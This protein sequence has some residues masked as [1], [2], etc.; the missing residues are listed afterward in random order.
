MPNESQYVAGRQKVFLI[1]KPE[2]YI[3]VILA[4]N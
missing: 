4:I 2:P 1:P 3:S